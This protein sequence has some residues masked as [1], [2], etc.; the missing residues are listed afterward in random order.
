MNPE[1]GDVR[2]QLLD[3]FGLCVDVKACTEPERVEILR[4]QRA[5]DDDAADFVR[6]WIDAEDEYRVRLKHARLR[7]PSV[8]VSD[9]ILTTVAT[10]C[11]AMGVDGHR[12][13]ITLVRAAAAH[14]AFTGRKA[15]APE[16]LR[17][18][19]P[20]VFSHRV[21]RSPFAD[22]DYDEQVLVEAL[23][24]VLGHSDEESDTPERSPDSGESTGHAAV[25]AATAHEPAEAELPSPPDMPDFDA[26]LDDARRTLSGRRN[27]SVSGDRRGRYTRSEP[28][29]SSGQ[30][31]LALDA[32]I[33]AAAPHQDPGSGSGLAVDIAP[34]HVRSKVRTRKV[35][36]S[37][38]LCV[39]ASG[40]MGAS[41]R[42]D[43]AKAVD[44]RSPCRRLPA[45]R[46]SRS[47]VVSR[48]RRR[49]RS[50]ADS[51]RRA[52]T[53]QA[54]IAS[55][56]RS[57]TARARP[58]R[59]RSS[60]S[61]LSRVGTPRYV[62]W[63]VLVTDGRANVGLDGGL[64]SEDARAM[65]ARVRASRRQRTRD[66]HRL[67]RAA[68]MPRASLPV[69]PTQS[70]CGSTRSTERP[71]PPR[72]ATESRRTRPSTAR[73]GCD[74]ME[75]RWEW[76]CKP[77]SVVD[78]HLSGTAVADGLTR[79]TRATAGPALTAPICPCS[80]WGLPSRR[81]CRDAGA[82]LPHRFSFS[83]ARSAGESSF[84][85]HFPSR[86]RALPLAG[87][88]PCGVRTFLTR[89]KRPTRSSGPLRVRF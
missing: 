31:D 46:P 75:P 67:G 37:I 28:A 8:E 83:P 48:R 19:A 17:A 41:D 52:R 32:T 44:P 27:E 71:S 43:A 25:I 16:D 76:A 78:D 33:R 39:D 66:R 36:A 22:R 30:I 9:E 12:G 5:F 15:V 34:E 69:R 57:D 47:R 73:S 38:V 54:A 86:H 84:L 1:E 63:L 79:A 64:G 42:M 26:T 10:L 20:L 62:P 87:T 72:S 68:R 70:T 61:K 51:Q 49:G 3:R 13:D 74:A 56:R 2:P 18:V 21:R 89:P 85:W 77:D 88:L 59:V 6:Q 81:V 50:S 24:A 60:C 82:L 4:R 35:G 45:S 80:G 7:L 11:V 29:R 53:S 58:R 40:S 23:T 14:V 65:A 55:D